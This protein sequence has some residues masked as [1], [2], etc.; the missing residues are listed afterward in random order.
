MKKLVL[1]IVATICIPCSLFSIDF[2]K[3]KSLIENY[4]QNKELYVSALV[5]YGFSENQIKTWRFTQQQLD[6]YFP[7]LLSEIQKGDKVF[8]TNIHSLKAI[9]DVTHELSVGEY[10]KLM[11]FIKDIEIVASQMRDERL[12]ILD[13]NVISDNNGIR[14]IGYNLTYDGNGNTGGIVPTDETLYPGGSLVQLDDG[15]RMTRDGYKFM[16]WSYDKDASSWLSS[17]KINIS[18]DIT[19]YAVWI[20]LDTINQQVANE[21]QRE[22]NTNTQQSVGYTVYV[23]PSGSKYHR[24]NCRTIRG[25]KTAMRISDAS[26]RGYTACKV[27]NP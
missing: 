17:T 20:S 25:S 26:S 23:T 11:I 1:L 16:G 2:E 10:D 4:R 6:V 21:L 7:V 18:H 13:K 27:C 8:S 15:K 3:L 9:N 19:L 14:I 12:K 5:D 22:E 24:S